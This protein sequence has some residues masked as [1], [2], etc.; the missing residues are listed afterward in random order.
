MTLS[1]VVLYSVFFGW[2][3]GLLGPKIIDAIGKGYRRRELRKILIVELTGLRRRL[4]GIAATMG[5][6]SKAQPQATTG[7]SQMR[8][9]APFLESHIPSLALFSEDFQRRALEL[10]LRLQN[11]NLLA[12]SGWF[13]FR[14]TFDFPT[15]E[16][17]LD[18]AKA[19][20]E[21]TYG[22]MADGAQESADLI[23]ELL[24]LKRYC[25]QTLLRNPLPS[26]VDLT[27]SAVAGRS[28]STGD[29]LQK[30]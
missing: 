23:G 24:A 9:G 25:A 29:P 2:L 6:R 13:Y 17:N 1:W 12:D 18:I 11:L 26:S 28:F 19:S 20:A 30:C 15:S 21:S 22:W 7:F 4:I 16:R 8:F 5:N 14:K 3:L 10:M 27:T